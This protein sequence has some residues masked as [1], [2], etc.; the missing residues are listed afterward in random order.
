MIADFEILKKQLA[1]LAKVINSF[2]CEAVQLKVV[3]LVLTGEVVAGSVEEVATSGKGATGGEKGKKKKAKKKAEKGEAAI[4][5]RSS[6]KGAVPILTQL[7]EEGYF[8]QGHTINNI[9][10]YVERDKAHKLKVTSLSGPLARFVRDSKLKRDKNADGQYE[11]K[12]P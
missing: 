6:K 4:K 11:Y 9:V 1:E 12:Q 7:I 10:E 3:E 5:R 8:K 2:Q